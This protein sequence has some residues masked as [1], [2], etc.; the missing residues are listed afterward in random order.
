M[1]MIEQQTDEQMMA[2]YMKL[3][4]LELAQVLINCNKM[5]DQLTIELR[6][7]PFRIDPIAKVYKIEWEDTTA[8]NQTKAG[9]TLIECPTC[10]SRNLQN[11]G[12]HQK[13]MEC[14]SEWSIAEEC[15]E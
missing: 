7:R 1:M 11:I 10:K 2:N 3:T 9:H 15:H 14:G 4:K 12:L 8:T 6:L 13:C 5:V